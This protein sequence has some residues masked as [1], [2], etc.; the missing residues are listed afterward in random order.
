MYLVVLGVC[1]L[2]MKLGG[3]APV[4]DWPWW[5]VL[6]P[7]AGA[8]LWWWYADSSGLT[9]RR[10][11]DK[12]DARKADRRRKNLEALGLDTKKRRRP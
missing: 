9:K 3:W 1:F 8:V 10:E 7:F 2:V 11:M 5:G 4:A 12:M 6:L